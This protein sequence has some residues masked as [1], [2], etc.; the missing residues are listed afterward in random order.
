MGDDTHRSNDGAGAQ[1]AP[2]APPQIGTRDVEW[3]LGH[4]RTVVATSPIVWAGRG[5]TL[6][7][8]L[9][10]HFIS[11]L[12]PVSLIDLAQALGTQP[13]AT[14][15]M[16]DRLVDNGLVRRIRDPQDGRRV[17]L[18]LTADAAPI[19]GTTDPGTAQRLKAILR[20]MDPQVHRRV[21]D[22]LR[23]T[24]QRASD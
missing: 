21:I 9:A 3:L 15:A 5:M 10:L 24:I 14:S 11:A 4:L 13:P 22:V 2:G 12:A 17:Q 8:L 1:A 20:S 7:Q 23:D 16:V 6:L 18:T 19:L